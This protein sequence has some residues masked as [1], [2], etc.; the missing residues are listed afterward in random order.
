MPAIP[1]NC[2]VCNQAHPIH[3]IETYKSNWYECSSC[4]NM[5][6]VQKPH[7]PLEALDFVRHFKF[8]HR[9]FESLGNLVGKKR[10]GVEYYRY[11]ENEIAAGRQGKWAK[12]LEV[13]LEEFRVH[14]VPID[15]Q[16]KKILDVSGEPGF[17]CQDALKAGAAE[18]VVT[19]FADNVV[20]VMARSL[21]LEAHEC[22][23]AQHDLATI[24]A[25]RKFDLIF[26]R[27]AIG[28][29][30]DLQK[31]FASLKSILTGDGLV[32]VSYSPTSRAVCA[33]W[34]FDDY[35]YLRQY[36]IDYVTEQAVQAGLS[37][38][39]GWPIAQYKFD[40]NLHWMQRLLTRPYLNHVFSGKGA[41][42][43]YQKNVALL[44][45]VP[46]DRSATQ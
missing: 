14:G 35:T 7:Y 24:F 12:Q 33:R 9:K 40:I 19:A 38:K 2:S 10:Q 15:L 5:W 29:C 8:L 34:M 25:G 11:Y 20:N 17:F 46:P 27:F 4:S 3:K 26:I 39:G 43:R 44:Y 28:F 41:E 32:Y 42:E 21:N 16:G 13:V 18:A 37:L 6:R 1:T 36:G 45:N 31:L 22:D 23:F 30:C